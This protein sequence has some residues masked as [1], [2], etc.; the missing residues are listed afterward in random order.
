M[1]PAP[2]QVAAFDLSA[3]RLHPVPVLQAGISRISPRAKSSF[4]HVA[5]VV[6]GG[7]VSYADLNA[8][9]WFAGGG[10]NLRNQGKLRRRGLSGAEDANE[11][12]RQ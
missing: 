6:Q 2:L 10:W 12:Q 4:A 11:Q 1:I 9:S 8:F 7:V 3:V 5:G